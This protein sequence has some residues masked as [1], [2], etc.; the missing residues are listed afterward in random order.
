MTAFARPAPG[1]RDVALSPGASS[2]RAPAVSSS[3]RV[4]PSQAREAWPRRRSMA[5]SSSQVGYWECIPT[6]RAT[7]AIPS[8]GPALTP[9]AILHPVGTA[10]TDPEQRDGHRLEEVPPLKAVERVEL[11]PDLLPF[12]RGAE[13]AADEQ[14]QRLGGDG[15]AERRR[16][17][18]ALGGGRLDGQVYLARPRPVGRGHVIKQ[19]GRLRPRL[20]GGQ[21]DLE[22]PAVFQLAD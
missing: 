21:E 8:G 10:Q 13:Q 19:P 2:D 9:P 5:G 16:H 22:L 4:T 6:R 14:R 11:W 1:R 7:P 17:D 20:V 15:G 12:R 3:R 18:P